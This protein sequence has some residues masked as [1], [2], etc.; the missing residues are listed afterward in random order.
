MRRILLSLLLRK[1]NF[2]HTR[3]IFAHARVTASPIFKGGVVV[4]CRN[5]DSVQE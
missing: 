3:K 4:L 5:I 2:R 1:N